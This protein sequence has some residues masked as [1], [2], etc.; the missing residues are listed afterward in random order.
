[1]LMHT[2]YFKIVFQKDMDVTGE[3]FPYHLPR[4]LDELA[5]CCFVA[6]DFEFSGISKI[7]PSNR[8]QTLQD[9]YQEVKSAADKYQILQVGLTICHEDTA[10]GQPF[11]RD[12]STE[13]RKHN[14]LKSN[15]N[16]YSEA[17][18]PVPESHY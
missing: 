2:S 15:S 13:K 10:T 7:A 18:Q 14:Q 4:I 11:K 3:S 6:L 9:R 8:I 17:V 12:S 5:S 1:M 16:V